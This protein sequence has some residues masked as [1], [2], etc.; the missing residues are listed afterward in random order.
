M[1]VSD[2]ILL[3][4]EGLG[5][6]LDESEREAAERAFSRTFAVRVYDLQQAALE[7]RES[8][9]KSL[10]IKRVK[11]AADEELDTARFEPAGGDGVRRFE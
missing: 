10:G 7:L 3:L 4:E 6:A 8:L 1:N 2:E 11:Q 9:I 5:R